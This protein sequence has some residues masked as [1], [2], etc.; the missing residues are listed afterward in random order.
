M[1][2]NFTT[3][4]D[5]TI[6]FD[7]HPVYP[8]IHEHLG[9]LYGGQIDDLDRFFTD[10][11]RTDVRPHNEVDPL[12]RQIIVDEMIVPRAIQTVNA[13]NVV[14][15]L[16]QMR[17]SLLATTSQINDGVVV[18]SPV[19]WRKYERLGTRGLRSM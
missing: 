1:A 4:T 16:I 14:T 9:R 3:I 2:Q 13:N 10:N 15:P 8:E 12:I 7:P 18:V 17:L 6:V 19:C 11:T 5:F